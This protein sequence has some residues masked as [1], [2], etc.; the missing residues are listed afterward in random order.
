MLIGFPEVVFGHLPEPPRCLACDGDGR[1]AALPHAPPG[2]GEAV[3]NLQLPRAK[4]IWMWTHA[5]SV[6]S[7][8][9]SQAA[10]SLGR[11]VALPL[12][13]TLEEMWSD[14]PQLALTQSRLT[15]MK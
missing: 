7:E 10:R 12:N 2:I 9:R 13:F 15:F 5:H 11:N 1:V 6:S 4:K 8:D 3:L 14:Q